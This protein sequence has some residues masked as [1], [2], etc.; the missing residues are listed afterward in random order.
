MTP[1]CC[2]TCQTCPS[3]SLMPKEEKLALVFLAGQALNA[4]NALCAKVVRFY[5]PLLLFRATPE[6]QD[7]LTSS[8]IPPT[9]SSSRMLHR[10]VVEI[11][12]LPSNSCFSASLDFSPE[13]PQLQTINLRDII[14][15]RRTQRSDTP[16]VPELQTI[17]LR[18]IS[19][20]PSS[21]P[22]NTTPPQ[23]YQFSQAIHWHQL[24]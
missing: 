8:N 9:L 24:P 10:L 23:H 7:E 17:N 12:S 16:E 21:S 11:Y 15:P 4:M 13:L 18:D 2:P 22:G 1:P 19:K 14:N 6:P 20:G 5:P 3:H